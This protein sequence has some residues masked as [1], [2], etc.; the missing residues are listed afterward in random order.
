MTKTKNRKRKI[1]AV[2]EEE[3]EPEAP[4]LTRSSDEPPPKKVNPTRRI[5]R[6]CFVGYVALTS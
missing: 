1:E 4:P 5:S 2:V 3:V 6:L